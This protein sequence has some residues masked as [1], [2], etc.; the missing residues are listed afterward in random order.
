LLNLKNKYDKIN[1]LTSNAGIPLLQID[2][3][4]DVDII[5]NINNYLPL[6]QSPSTTVLN[7]EK[8]DSIIDF[9]TINNINF[10]GIVFMDNSWM[11]KSHSAHIFSLNEWSK[12]NGPTWGQ[13]LIGLLDPNED[14]FLAPPLTPPH[15]PSCQ[16]GLNWQVG[17]KWKSKSLPLSFW[18]TLASKLEKK[19]SVSWQRGEKD[20]SEYLTWISSCEFIIT[21]DSLGLHIAQAFNRKVLALFGSTSPSEVDWNKDSS[22]LQFTLGKEYDDAKLIEEILP[23]IDKCLKN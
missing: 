5:E 21:H 7:L 8:S 16:I 1:W 4:I 19:Y 11:V 10:S 15:K 20:L 22:Y 3:I 6:I 9:L 13:K 18:Q 17:Q 2:Q 14:N 12:F 23:I